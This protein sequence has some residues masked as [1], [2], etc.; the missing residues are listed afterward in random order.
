MLI[1][2]LQEPY[3]AMALANQKLQGNEP[4]EDKWSGAPK[5][6]GGFNFIDTIEGIDFWWAVEEG[7]L[8]EITPAI[9]AHYPDIF[10]P[11][12]EG[13]TPTY[14]TIEKTPTTVTEG[15]EEK[16]FTCLTYKQ[17]LDAL[18]YKYYN[19]GVK[20]EPKT[21]DYYTTSRADLELYQIVEANEK[22]IKTKYCDP[23]RGDTVS[24]WVTEDFL[25]G[26]GESRVYV[27]LMFLTTK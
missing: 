15:I 6:A 11:E 19:G 18:A 16:E 21:G 24:S 13:L 14:A 23:K 5:S 9:K 8:P 17:K 25:K 27:P 26:F 1:K 2:D 7:K 10:P 22:E 12:I 20:W 4:N 3:K